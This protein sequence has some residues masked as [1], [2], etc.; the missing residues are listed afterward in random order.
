MHAAGA[1]SIWWWSNRGELVMIYS[2]V[3]L[4]FA[5][6]GAGPYS[7]DAALDERGKA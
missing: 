7:V 5:A 4:L 3:W 6:W 1:G 2:F